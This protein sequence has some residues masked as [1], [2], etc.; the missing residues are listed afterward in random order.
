[1]W[2]KLSV[3]IFFLLVDW[4]IIDVNI[5]IFIKGAKKYPTVREQKRIKD[6]LFSLF[7]SVIQLVLGLRERFNF[8]PSTEP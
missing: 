3:Q 1:M 6:S 2:T 7:L 5:C 4:H 8:N